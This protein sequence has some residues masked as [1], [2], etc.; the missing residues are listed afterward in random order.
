LVCYWEGLP[1]RPSGTPPYP[2][3]TLRMTWRGILNATTPCP[4]QRGTN[5]RQP[6]ATS[7]YAPSSGGQTANSRF[8]VVLGRF[9]G[10]FDE[11]F[12]NA[13]KVNRSAVLLTDIA[14]VGIRIAEQVTVIA[15]VGIRFA[16]LLI[17]IAAPGIRIALVGI[18][19]AAFGIVIASFLCIYAEL[20]YYSALS[21]IINAAHLIMNAA[22][23]IIKAEPGILILLPGI[24][25]LA[26]LNLVSGRA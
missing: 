13:A 4:R 7:P 26:C 8:L 16:L 21:G 1:P 2:S 6:N 17:R 25:V 9:W 12:V 3:T 10:V 14:A 19:I 22:V 23:G 15:S 20:L 5:S 24:I 18:R 11:K